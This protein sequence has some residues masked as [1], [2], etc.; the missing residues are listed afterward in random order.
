MIINLNAISYIT[1]SANKKSAEVRMQ[2]GLQ[3]TCRQH[4]WALY[5]LLQNTKASTFSQIPFTL[6]KLSETI[7]LVKPLNK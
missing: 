4:F 7:Y 1:L 2:D 5:L 6:I 3:F